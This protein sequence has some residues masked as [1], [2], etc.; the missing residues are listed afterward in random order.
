MRNALRTLSLDIGS[1]FP[2]R[3]REWRV[4]H[5]PGSDHVFAEDL[6]TGHRDRLTVEEILGGADPSSTDHARMP[7]E[8]ERPDL[9]GFGEPEWAEAQRRFKIIEKLV[10]DPEPSRAACD[11]HAKSHG[12]STSTLYR[13]LADYRAT[14][15]ISAL[16]PQR[17]GPKKGTRRID[18]NAELVMRSVFEDKFLTKQ[19]HSAADVVVEVHR[20]CRRAGIAPPTESTIRRRLSEIPTATMM[21]RRGHREMADSKFRRIMGQFPGA[22]QPLAVVQMDHTKLDIIVVDDLTR[23]PLGRPTITVAL[24]VYSR[25]VV[26]FHVSMEAAGAMAAGLCLTMA[27]LPKDRF[28]SDHGVTGKWPAFG[29]MRSVHL[30]NAKEFRGN[31]LRRAFDEYGIDLKLRPAKTPHFGGHI[32]RFMGRLADL[33]H[34]LPGTTFAS[35]AKRKGYDAEKEAVLTLGEV[36][37]YILEFIVNTYHLDYHDGI[38]MTPMHRWTTAIAGDDFTPGTGIPKVPADTR[39]LAIDFLPFE[40]RS[41]QTYGIVIEGIHYY[42]E[43]LRPLIGTRDAATG[44]PRRYV[45]RYDPRDMS[46][47]HLFDPETGSTHPIP[48]RDTSRPKAS[49]WS[50]RQATAEARRRGL[51]TVDEAAIFAALERQDAIVTEAAASTKEA[52]RTVQRRTAGTNPARPAPQPAAALPKPSPE[53]TQ[54]GCGD[55]LASLFSRPAVA[56]D[57]IVVAKRAPDEDKA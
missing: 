8:V 27:I 18:E 53:A 7:E 15:Q 14:R 33:M 30:D 52:R 49:L 56:F 38:M 50:I 25:M 31:V 46:V 55:D 20:Q 34:R 6:E 2:C 41:I 24:D 13:W 37:R 43:V 29:L 57:D 44:K 54:K 51:A 23:R 22:D 26:G 48:Y 45:V 40:E 5:V 36:E 11:A 1:T 10:D 42:H 17:R 28:L 4:T 19:R 16:V 9:S 21:R 47:V 12:V 39:K 32:E 35:P 3:G